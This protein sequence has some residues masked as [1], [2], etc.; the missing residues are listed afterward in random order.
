MNVYLMIAGAAVVFIGI[1]LSGC[2]EAHSFTSDSRLIGAWKSR[3]VDGQPLMFFPDGSW[4]VGKSEGTWT[5]E[6]EK[7]VITK[8]EMKGIV[9]TY[10]YTFSDSGTMLIMIDVQT[11]ERT[12]YEKI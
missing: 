7:L 11:Q 3:E 1:G 8:K 2:Q 5:I 12:V 6:N 4:S 10:N 9:F